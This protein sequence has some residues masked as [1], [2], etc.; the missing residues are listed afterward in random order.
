MSKKFNYQLINWNTKGGLRNKNQQTF[1]AKLAVIPTIDGKSNRLKKMKTFKISRDFKID[2]S[3]SN[4]DTITFI[5][6]KTNEI[7]IAT[8]NTRITS[9]KNVLRDLSSD[10]GIALGVSSLGQRTAEV[11]KI[12]KNAQIKYPK[13]KGWDITLTGHSLG[14]RIMKTVSKKTKLPAVIFNRGSSPLGVLGDKIQ[15][16]LDPNYN[17][18]QIIHYHTNKPSKGIIDVISASALLHKDEKHIAVDKK[19]DKNPHSLS[20][21]TGEGKRTNKWLEFVKKYRHTHPNLSYKQCLIDCK[22]IYH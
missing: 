21:F 4:R 20:N 19:S 12:V 17:K 2:Y 15:S 18:S 3:L 5:N 13:S 22:K 14:G 16:I 6:K 1:Y 11:L 9:K 10:V 8:S 7:V